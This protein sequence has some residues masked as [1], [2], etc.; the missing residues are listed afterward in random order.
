MEVYEVGIV[1]SSP[2][3]PGAV[4]SRLVAWR[5]SRQAGGQDC[6]ESGS[7]RIQVLDGALIVKG[8][9]TLPFVKKREVEAALAD[10]LQ[11]CFCG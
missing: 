9:T 4:R 1:I 6:F 10:F 8:T 11:Q 5:K 7:A 3:M 2:V